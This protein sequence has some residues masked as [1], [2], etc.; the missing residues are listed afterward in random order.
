MAEGTT[1]PAFDVGGGVDV[2][3]S[4]TTFL[5]LDAGDRIL[6]YPGP[7]TGQGLILNDERFYG[8]AF[9]VAIGGGFRF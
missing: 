9:R 6:K 4:D 2:H 3:T 7:S 8:H 1:L 5:R